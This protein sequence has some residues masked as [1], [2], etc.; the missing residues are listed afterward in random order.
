[1]DDFVKKTNVIAYSRAALDRDAPSI[2]RLAEL[3]G[4]MAHAESVRIRL[5]EGSR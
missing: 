2:I 4:L 1:V 3:E 5:K